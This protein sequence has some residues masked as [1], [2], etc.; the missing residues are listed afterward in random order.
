MMGSVVTASF[1]VAAVGAFYRLQ[2]K[3]VPHAELFLRVAVIAGVASAIAMAAPTGDL[4][5]RL[6][7]EHQP[8]GFAAMEGHFHTEDGAALTLVGQPDVENLT[9]DNPITVPHFLSV[10][11]H[12]RWNARIEGLT[13]FDRAT[14]PDNIPLLYYSYHL[15]VGLGTIFMALMAT[16]AALLYRGRLF[17]TRPALWALMLAFPLPFVANTAGWLTAELGRQPWVV[18]GVMRTADGHSTNV[19]SGN[20][21]FTLLGFMGVY[22]LLSLLFAFVAQ[23]ILAKGPA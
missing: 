11:T 15:M 19:S 17:R 13:A 7:A 14:W 18:Y 16:S 10:M 20:V 6:V 9:L 5:A 2:G 22:A 1:V 12:Q 8:V 3:H 23:R 4:Q 21:L